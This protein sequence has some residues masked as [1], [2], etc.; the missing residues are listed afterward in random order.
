MRLDL[1]VNLLS[2][3][4]YNKEL[5]TPQN[6]IIIVKELRRR[7]LTSIVNQTF[8]DIL[9]TLIQETGIYLGAYLQNILP[10][11]TFSAVTG[12]LTEA[13]AD[14]ATIIA[15]NYEAASGPSLI[16]DLKKYTCGEYQ[17]GLICLATGAQLPSPVTIKTR[18]DCKYYYPQPGIEEAE[19]YAHDLHE[20]FKRKECVCS[21]NIS[22]LMCELDPF[23]LALVDKVY[24]KNFGRTLEQ[25]VEDKTS[26]NLK[27]L[28]ETF[29]K[30]TYVSII[31]K[32]E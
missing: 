12:I 8:K 22:V 13:A 21:G 1:S 14:E 29:R 26:G 10:K 24:K 32:D 2:F 23:G 25:E 7:I 9:L 31:P 19:S 6:V 28:L 16:S 11:K 20:A 30:F 17:K 5:F 27:F 15:N 4:S 3:I 18:R